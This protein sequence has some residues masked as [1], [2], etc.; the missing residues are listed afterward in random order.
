MPR[1]LLVKEPLHKHHVFAKRHHRLQ[2]GADFHRRAGPFGPPVRRLH[3]VG[4]IDAGESHRRRRIHDC[5][6]ALAGLCGTNRPRFQPRQGKH[7][8]AAA[9]QEPSAVDR[10]SAALSN[11]PS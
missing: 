10:S 2:A 9:A 11:G 7:K 8:A 4:E 5:G 1:G 3:A 6:A